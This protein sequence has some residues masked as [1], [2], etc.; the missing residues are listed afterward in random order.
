MRSVSVRTCLGCR[1]KRNKADLRRF[2][3]D[4]SGRLTHDADGVMGG[5]GV[6]C[7]RND[8]CLQRLLKGTKRLARALRLQDVSTDGCA[9]LKAG[10]LVEREAE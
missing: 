3:A 2:A 4:G 7:C 8:V 9:G 10:D 1:K 5:R 6:Y